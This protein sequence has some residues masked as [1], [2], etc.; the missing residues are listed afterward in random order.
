MASGDAFSYADAARYGFY[1]H[2]AVFAVRRVWKRSRYAPHMLTLG[3]EWLVSF[4]A[5]RRGEYLRFVA[6]TALPRAASKLLHSV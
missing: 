4:D 3:L 2:L 5:L 1:A 6:L